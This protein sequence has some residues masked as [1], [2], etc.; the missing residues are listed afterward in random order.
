MKVV[1]Q[2][3]WAALVIAIAAST[4]LEARE[5]KLSHQWPE[6]DARHRAARVLMAELRK[7]GTDLSITIH[8]NSSLK[9]KAPDQLGAMIDGKI[10]MAVYPLT[11]ARAKIPELAIAG[12]PGIPSNAEVA[13]LLKGT[14]FED[15]LQDVCAKNGFRVLT[16][17]WVGGGIA[18]RSKPIS[19]PESVK[20]LPA[21]GGDAFN[22]MLKAAGANPQSMPS[23]DIR[24]TLEADK[25]DVVL[26]S[27]ESFMSYRIPELTKYAT[28][29]GS[30]GIFT[31]F[32]PV[33]I[34]NAVWES[35]SETERLALQEAAAASE[36]YFEATQREAEEAAVAAFTK[37]GATVQQ[38]S[39]E[40]YAGWLEVAKESAWKR[41]QSISPAARDLFNAMLLSFINSE[42]R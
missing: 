39:F 16:W 33:I 20:G 2:A 1:S 19:G 3:I 25:L 23:S 41:Y 15:K 29:G 40:Q 17:W 27:Y 31:V 32:T 10:E 7:R 21:R 26:T 30:Y 37:A 24:P 13:G 5:L 4:N 28:L 22:E 14:E 35:L 8:P 11:Y 36:I 12:L 9:I 38:L 34:S 6:T 18:S 42:R